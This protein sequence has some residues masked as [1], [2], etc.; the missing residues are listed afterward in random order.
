M[1]LISWINQNLGLIYILST[2]L[3]MLPIVLHTKEVI[4]KI[5]KLGVFIVW[6]CSPIFL[7]IFTGFFY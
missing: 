6:L 7:P 1:N 5:G 4:N 2:Y 3:C